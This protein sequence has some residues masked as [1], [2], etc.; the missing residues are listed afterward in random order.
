MVLQI[1]IQETQLLF[2][3]LNRPDSNTNVCHR[4]VLR[5]A[6]ELFS[7]RELATIFGRPIK[8]RV[9]MGSASTFSQLGKIQTH[10]VHN[11]RLVSR[12]TTVPDA[13]ARRALRAYCDTYDTYFMKQ[14]NIYRV[15]DKQA[16]AA[17]QAAEQ[18]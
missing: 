5:K 18:A 3:P 7:I 16:M 6:L 14:G 15:R 17:L 1:S 13:E 9:V 4:A 12:E 8:L 11:G 10:H 2:G